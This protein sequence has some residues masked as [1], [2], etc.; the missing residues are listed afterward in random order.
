MGKEKE[1]KVILYFSKGAMPNNATAT[2]M[3][4]NE[5]DAINKAKIKLSLDRDGDNYQLIQ[6]ASAF[7]Q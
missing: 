5:A 6:G 3:A 4:I 7:L 2:V 1:Y